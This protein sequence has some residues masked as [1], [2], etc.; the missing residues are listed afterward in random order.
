MI[1]GE[2]Q[3]VMVFEQKYEPPAQPIKINYNYICPLGFIRI[4]IIVSI[5]TDS[6]LYLYS[7]DF[8]RHM[9]LRFSCLLAVLPLG[10][11]QET[12]Q[13]SIVWT[14]TAMQHTSIVQLDRLILSY[15][16]P[17]L[18]SLLCSMS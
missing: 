9:I 6:I 15:L 13:A 5:A 18:L 8:N 12:F 14:S 7:H 16:R 17:L 11:Y 4:T 2:S 10:S 1:V 3:E